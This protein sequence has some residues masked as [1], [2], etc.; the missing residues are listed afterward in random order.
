MK[1]EAEA[2]LALATMAELLSVLE[3]VMEFI[4]EGQACNY[5]LAA[6][7]IWNQLR[8]SKSAAC[9]TLA[10]WENGSDV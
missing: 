6:E 10:D 2:E 1:R 5:D 4:E 9:A 7:T 8:E 3:P